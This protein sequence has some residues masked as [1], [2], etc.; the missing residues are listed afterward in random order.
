MVRYCLG[1]GWRRA[2]EKRRKESGKVRRL[3]LLQP[4]LTNLLF[5]RQD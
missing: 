4:F 2:E 5:T 3:K 1:Y